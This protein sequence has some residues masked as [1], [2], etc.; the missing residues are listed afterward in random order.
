MAD[1]HSLL[2]RAIAGLE[3]NSEE[4]RQA[5]YQRVRAVL[6]DS[7]RNR[8][9]PVSDIEIERER[10]ALEDA[11]QKIELKSTVHKGRGGEISLS[12]DKAVITLHEDAAAFS[13]MHQS[14]HL[15]LDEMIRD[16]DHPRAP[17]R[18]RRDRD[19]ILKWLGVTHASE[20]TAASHEQ[21]ALAFEQYV[22]EGR[23]P[24]A[25]L[26]GAFKSFN[27]WASHR[28]LKDAGI[29]LTDEVRGVMDRMLATDEELQNSRPVPEPELSESSTNPHGTT[30]DEA[31]SW[32]WADTTFWKKAG[33]IAAVIWCALIAIFSAAGRDFRWFE[34]SGTL[35]PA[36]I[37]A[38]A[39]LIIIL[40]FCVGVPWLL[41]RPASSTAI[42]PIRAFEQTDSRQ[43]KVR[44]MKSF[45]VPITKAPNLWRL[46]GCGYTLLG[47]FHDPDVAPL[48]FS[49]HA[50]TVFWIP[51]CTLGIYLVR[52]TGDRSYQFHGTI[53]TENFGKLYPN[54]VLRL[55]ASCLLE[56]AI[57]IVGILLIF[58]LIAL[59]FPHG[60]YGFRLRI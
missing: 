41:L 38:I 42:K 59:V 33:L 24:S 57:W 30:F 15:W 35:G 12:K 23:A 10:V 20:I 53:S 17:A 16:A 26:A 21:W 5:L 45:T 44:Q 22:A 18:L 27:S 4:M 56:S 32:L 49:V 58:G 8:Q 43:L 46:N 19:S 51:V 55:A 31:A 52:A 60:H 3:S 25:A 37:T 9:S 6:V 2:S 36:S 50:F 1:Y 13:F 7:L 47:S 11:I 28:P 40:T 29:P 54:G 48:Y 34:Y 14:A 39:G